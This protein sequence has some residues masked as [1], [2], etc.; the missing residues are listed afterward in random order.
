MNAYRVRN[1]LIWLV[2]TVSLNQACKAIFLYGGRGQ[3]GSILGRFFWFENFAF[4][5]CARTSVNRLRFPFV[6][7]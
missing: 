6:Q 3:I 1:N 5:V 4:L 2:E 7:L